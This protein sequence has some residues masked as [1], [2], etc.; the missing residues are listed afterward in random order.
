MR[1]KEPFAL[2]E[3]LTELI[4][5]RG[6]AR[7]RAASRWESAWKTVAGP[8]LAE[9]SRV[10]QSRLGVLEVT[11]ANSVLAQEIAFQK[12]DLIAALSRLLPDE[13]IHDLR[14]RVSRSP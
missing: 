11:V 3:V 12:T 7:V 13:P 1:Q 9:Q 8:V 14:V 4:A 6:L 5:R 2:G 10:L